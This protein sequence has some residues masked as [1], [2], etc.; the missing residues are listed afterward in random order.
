MFGWKRKKYGGKIG[1]MKED[2]PLNASQENEALVKKHAEKLW[3][4]WHRMLAV[5]AMA[6]AGAEVAKSSNETAVILGTLVVA[7]IV[8]IIVEQAWRV[9]RESQSE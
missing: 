2:K 6:G 7:G 5:G 8:S 4:W 1:A 3:A 9:R